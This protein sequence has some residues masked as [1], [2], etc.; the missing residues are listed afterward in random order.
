MPP[1]NVTIIRSET[2]TTITWDEM[3]FNTRGIVYTVYS[4][5][6]PEAT[7]SDEWIVEAVNLT[8]T[9]WQDTDLTLEKKFYKVTVGSQIR[10]SNS[11]NLSSG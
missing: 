5:D 8:T 4:S 11:N 10:S 3:P 1:Q 9:S 7:F 2:G 6:D